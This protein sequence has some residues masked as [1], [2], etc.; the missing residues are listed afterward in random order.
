MQGTPSK[1][2]V[3]ALTLCGY[4]LRV[5]G[6]FEYLAS[7]KMMLL[8]NRLLLRSVEARAAFTKLRRV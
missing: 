4:D 6:G 8:G 5:V 2:V 1:L 7:L 3:F